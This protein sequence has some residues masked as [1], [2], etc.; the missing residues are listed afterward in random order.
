M[1]SFGP[2]LGNVDRFRIDGNGS[3]IDPSGSLPDSVVNKSYVDVGLSIVQNDL[4]GFPDELKNLTNAEI[5]QIQ[6]I[7]SVI[8][9]PSQWGYLSN[10]DQGLSTTNSVT[11]ANGDF[12]DRV[13]IYDSG[14]NLVFD[15]NASA[16]ESIM[17]TRMR[18]DAID[19]VD[20]NNDDYIRSF[21]TVLP[22]GQVFVTKQ[23][24][25]KEPFTLYRD[26]KMEFRDSSD[27]LKLVLDPNATN[28][29]NVDAIDGIH[30][31]PGL[32]SAINGLGLFIRAWDTNDVGLLDVNDTLT[33]IKNSSDT[34]LAEFSGTQADILGNT[35][36]SSGLTVNAGGD[37]GIS[38]GVT[39][40]GV[41]SQVSTNTG[42]ISTNASNISTNTS[43]IGNKLFGVNYGLGTKSNNNTYNL[44][45]GIIIAGTS[46]TALTF[47]IGDGSQGIGGADNCVLIAG[48]TGACTIGE[49]N[50]LLGGSTNNIDLGTGCTYIGYDNNI[51]GA[52]SNPNSLT[53]VGHNNIG[54]SNISGCTIVGSN[55]T[56]STVNQT[57]IG[58]GNTSGASN[59]VI[60]G[61][62]NDDQQGSG[63]IGNTLIGLGST[64]LSGTFNGLSTVVG[65]N[66]TAQNQATSVGANN[67]VK[68]LSAAL[69]FGN[70]IDGFNNSFSFGN[71]NTITSAD[72]I[73]FGQNLSSAIPGIQ[74]ATGFQQGGA[75]AGAVF[76]A[77]GGG[78]AR[79]S[80]IVSSRRYKKNIEY[81]ENTDYRTDDIYKLKP[82]S[83]NYK[84][85]DVHE[86]GLIA[87]EV[88]ELD[89]KLLN[90]VIV[91]GE[92][93]EGEEVDENE[94]RKD[95]FVIQS[96]KYDKLIVPVI[97]EMKKLKEQNEKLNKQLNEL[98]RLFKEHVKSCK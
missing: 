29:D 61:Q 82:V 74:F 77:I 58:N 48:K 87:E 26:G 52:S 35:L 83:F 2:N 65:Y 69:G 20:G 9:T 23:A 28:M 56:F 55:N 6:N 22:S 36:N 78:I 79:L 68:G 98:S 88:Y 66:S 44:S 80:S 62:G 7:G 53:I 42:N 96:I 46:Q 16:T 81:V 92:P 40:N 17:A 57:I 51:A 85:N 91:W 3:T 33:R 75:G 38:G 73:L 84:K 8:I 60:V 45:K 43:N 31:G 24:D 95:G 11:F 86:V 14:N 30:F 39:L 10:L 70:S 54:S 97:A 50:V 94:P 89:S 13:R 76:E 64:I 93:L 18:M 15:F 4:D 1:S 25:L 32:G 59:S 41:N 72:G 49:N 90:D 21:S 27:A 37:V 63:N 5:Q 19:L 71:G 12:K 67:T 47:D 34:V